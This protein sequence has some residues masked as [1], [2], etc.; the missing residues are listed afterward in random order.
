M[1]KSHN[2]QENVCPSGGFH[3]QA[4][5]QT[6]CHLNNGTTQTSPLQNP[7]AKGAECEAG[8]TARPGSSSQEEKIK[9]RSAARAPPRPGGQATRARP[10]RSEP[11]PSRGGRATGRASTRARGFAAYPHRRPLA[12]PGT[13][14][15][16]DYAPWLAAGPGRTARSPPGLPSP[17]LAGSVRTRVGTVAAPPP[18]ARP[19]RRRDASSGANAG[20]NRGPAAAPARQLEVA[21]RACSRHRPREA[22]AGP[23]LLAPARAATRQD[24]PPSAGAEA[25]DSSRGPRS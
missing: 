7:S 11:L 21:A 16:S 2:L 5:K 25:A 23:L 15:S 13:G 8:S 1:R 10:F 22:T 12:G 6:R 14:S 4:E 3:F 24:A 18:P 9:L 19:N 17:G 20:P